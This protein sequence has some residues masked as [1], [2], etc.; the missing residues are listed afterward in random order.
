MRRAP[1]APACG[2]ASSAA[3]AG[4]PGKTADKQR[5]EN[6][7]APQA[8]RSRRKRCEAS[9][10]LGLVLLLELFDLALLLL[11]LLLLLL[12]LALGLLLL[13]FLVLHLVSHQ[14]TAAR[15]EGA[16]D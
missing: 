14:E 9:G 4:P 12:N 2:R 6:G 8:A 1:S 15:A 7:S 3:L 5:T 11:D 10:L 16:A 13:D